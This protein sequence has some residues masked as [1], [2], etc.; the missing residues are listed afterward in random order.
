MQEIFS[1]ITE[2][3]RLRRQLRDENN[4]AFANL[5]ATFCISTLL[6]GGY[7]VFLM[8]TD[9]FSRNFFLT[10]LPGNLL[11]IVIIMVI[12]LVLSYITTIKSKAI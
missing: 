2:T 12:F 6:T 11:L 9:T 10:T 1:D 7:F 3:N 5:K 8:F 4:A